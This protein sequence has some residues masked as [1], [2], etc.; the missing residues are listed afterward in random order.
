MSHQPERQALA[1]EQDHQLGTTAAPQSE[2]GHSMPPP[3]FNLNASG[4]G[5]PIQQ[6]PDSDSPALTAPPAQLMAAHDTGCDCNV[7]QTKV[8]QAKQ[9]SSSAPVQMYQDRNDRHVFQAANTFSDGPIRMR[10]QMRIYAMTEPQ[11]SFEIT[12]ESGD[13]QTVTFTREWARG[14]EGKAVLRGR[15]RHEIQYL[16]SQ[17]MSS[18]VENA[19][20]GLPGDPGL[21]A[22]FRFDLEMAQHR[23]ER[24]GNERAEQAAPHLIEEGESGLSWLRRGYNSDRT[25]DQ[26]LS[27]TEMRDLHRTRAAAGNQRSVRALYE[28]EHAAAFNSQPSSVRHAEIRRLVAQGRINRGTAPRTR[29]N[30]DPNPRLQNKLY[31]RFTRLHA[32]WDIGGPENTAVYSPLAGEV[33]HIGRSS[34]Y[35]NHIRIRH[36]RAPRTEAG[37]G[38]RSGR[39]GDTNVPV[40]TNYCHL[41][42]TLVENGQAV[43]PGQAIGLLGDTGSGGMHLHF[44]VMADPRTPQQIEDGRREAGLS[45]ANEEGRGIHAREWFQEVTGSDEPYRP[46][47]V[48]EEAAGESAGPPVEGE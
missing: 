26:N 36:A 34:T 30:P 24:L 29:D 2:S 48:T 45:S 25:A 15:I 17:E 40:I 19:L 16:V 44:S 21:I 3:P 13:P 23:A 47:T 4:A 12:N 8:A 14:D 38:V 43:F 27:E 31:T 28:R 22:D 35:G 5:S 41:N 9:D 32:A 39:A 37:P 20:D 7:C 10:D 18:V 46:A 42:A 6:K 33:I 1:P 11:L